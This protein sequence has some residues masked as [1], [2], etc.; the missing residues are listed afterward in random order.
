MTTGQET[1]A[2]DT[3]AARASRD[4]G[5]AEERAARDAARQQ[6]ADD[7]ASGAAP[8]TG[9]TL[10]NA[11]IKATTGIEATGVNTPAARAS[12]SRIDTKAAEGFRANVYDD[13]AGN[14]TIGY[15]HKLTADEL[16]SGMLTLPDGTKLEL[17]KGV[18][19]AQAD[20]IYEQDKKTNGNAAMGALEKKGVDTSKLNEATKDA[21][22][23]LAFNAGPGVFDKSPKLVAALKAN[24]IQA[25]SD[26]L[27]TTGRTANGQQMGGLVTRANARADQ[28]AASLEPNQ[29]QTASLVDNATTAA[30]PVPTSPVQAGGGNNV[31]V[32]QNSTTIASA[33]LPSTRND[34]NSYRLGNAQAAGFAA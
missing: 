31:N 21:L 16:K 29:I 5:K 14:P 11:A 1:S 20:A 27:R 22:N 4:Q 10:T 34:E 32:V 30:T 15:G 23:D 33:P 12:A 26:E 6:R 13:G 18:T 2:A 25:I 8:K 24:D 3:A 7:K 17:S 19:R 28:V 9:S